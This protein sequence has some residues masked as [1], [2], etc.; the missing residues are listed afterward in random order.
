MYFVFVGRRGVEPHFVSA[1]RATCRTAKLRRLGFLWLRYDTKLT[2]NVFITHEFF[3][4][5]ALTGYLCGSA[6]SNRFQYNCSYFRCTLP[7]PSPQ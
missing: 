1:P 2:K 7:L 5:F 6:E 3:N 4:S